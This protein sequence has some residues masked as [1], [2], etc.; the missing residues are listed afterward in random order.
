MAWKELRFWDFGEW[1]VIKEQLR[2]SSPYCPAR[3]D[4][5]KA[6]DL[7]PMDE[8]KVAIFGQDPYP[9]VKYATGVAFDIPENLTEFPMT[10]GNIFSEYSSDLKY[11]YPKNGSLL[12]WVK[13]GVFLWNVLPTCEQG[14]PLS[15]NW[16]EYHMLTQEIVEKLSEREIVFAFLG[17]LARD[18]AKYVDESK[19]FVIETS[20]PSPRG[21]LNSKVPFLGSRIFSRI[22]DYLIQLKKGPIDWKL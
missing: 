15:H 16:T 18:F 9:D 14:K 12:P 3:K 10:L 6:M 13:Q 17:G 20:H 19:S 2:D 4:I 8:V 22:N 5:F 21:N 7:L 11:D 1:D